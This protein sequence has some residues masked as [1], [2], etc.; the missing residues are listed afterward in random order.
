MV[1]EHMFLLPKLTQGLCLV[2]Y[3]VICAWLVNSEFCA[4][5]VNTG[6]AL[7]KLTQHLRLVS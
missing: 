7:G 4:C 3:C 2:F 5:C 1:S 6:F